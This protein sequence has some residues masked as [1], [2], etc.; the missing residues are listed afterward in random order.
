[1]NGDLLIFA[2]EFLLKEHES[3]RWMS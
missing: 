3:H 2:H 1:M